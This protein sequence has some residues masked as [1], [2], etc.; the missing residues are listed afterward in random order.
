[1]YHE[2]QRTDGVCHSLEV[3]R[4]TVCEVVHWIYVPT[5]TSAVV[6]VSSDDA[7]HDWVAEVHVRVGH[8]YLRAEYHL[9]VFNLAV[10]HGLEESEVL[11]DWTVAVWRCYTWLGRCTFLLSYLLGSLF[12]DIGLALFDKLNS[13]VVELLEIVGSVVDIAPFEAQPS[14]V[15][16]DRIYVFHIFF[17]GVGVV[18]SEV[19]YAV[20][21][22][23]DAKV[24][25]DGFHVSDV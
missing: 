7:V 23:C 24:H 21:F 22:L 15:L 13:E 5:T 1:M 10:L 4:L 17:D 9:A 3:V 20:V 8:V 14:D 25:A 6:R 11:V 16:L 12:V 2:L 18:K 19:A